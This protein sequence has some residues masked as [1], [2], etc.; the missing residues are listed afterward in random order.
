MHRYAK[1]AVAPT[2][3]ALLLSACGGQE[4]APQPTTPA[5]APS[6]DTDVKADVKIVSCDANAWTQDAAIEVT[7]SDSAPWKYV[8]GLTIKDSSGTTSEARFVKNRVEPGQVIKES[9]PGDTPL[10][11][12]VTCAVS[13]A[14]RLPPQ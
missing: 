4:P 13:E 3:L 6:G 10:K 5:A 1:L 12:E 11:G 9:I 2:A 14:K 7:N 8:V